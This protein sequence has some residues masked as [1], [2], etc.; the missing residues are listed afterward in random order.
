MSTVLVGGAIANKLHNGGEAWV[1]L[2]WILGLRRL[3]LDVWFVEQIAADT[4]VN[5]AGAPAPFRESENRRYFDAIVE[6]FGLGGRAALLYGDGEQ[7][8]GA[9]LEDVAAAAGEA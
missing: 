5:A 7:S 3:G 4:C 1:R 6:D 2:S 9:S 8:S